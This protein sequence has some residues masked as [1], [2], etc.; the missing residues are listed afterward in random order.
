[1]QLAPVQSSLFTNTPEC[2]QSLRIFLE[3]A[4]ESLRGQKRLLTIEIHT[5]VPSGPLKKALGAGVSPHE[6]SLAP[7]P[8]LV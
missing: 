1:M 6:N 8:G 5:R 7:R 3:A 2:R 4:K